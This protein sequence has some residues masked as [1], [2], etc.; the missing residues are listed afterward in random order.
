M[1]G[2]E[3]VRAATKLKLRG[4]ELDPEDRRLLD[5]NIAEASEAYKAAGDYETMCRALAG[6]REA[7]LARLDAVKAPDAIH[8][9][10][11]IAVADGEPLGDG[12]QVA[13]RPADFWSGVPSRFHNLDR[14][15][16]S[17]KIKLRFAVSRGEPSDVEIKVRDRDGALA[18]ANERAATVTGGDQ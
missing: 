5:R 8:T 2:L 16:V 13:M 15:T 14:F 11:L 18:W 9:R 6:W 1:R 4:V 10:L 7:L 12:V 17:R 3:Q